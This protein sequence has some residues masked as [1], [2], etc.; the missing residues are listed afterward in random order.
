[1][2]VF[3]TV[4]SIG[5]D[6]DP[7]DHWDHLCLENT[8]YIPNESKVD[9]PMHLQDDWLT[10]IE[11][12]QKQRDIQQQQHMHISFTQTGSTA[13]MNPIK[14]PTSSPDII[15]NLEKVSTSTIGNL[16]ESSALTIENQRELLLQQLKSH[17]ELLLQQLK[18]QRNLLLQQLEG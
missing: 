13:V 8:M 11:Q 4:D 3:S 1:M 17:R 18:I 12:Q 5:Q 15:G 6:E 9:A 10:S 2:T 16:N 7:P 14:H